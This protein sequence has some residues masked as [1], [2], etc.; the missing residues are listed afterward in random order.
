MPWVA[1]MMPDLGEADIC[2]IKA[3]GEDMGVMRILGCRY[4]FERPEIPEDDVYDAPGCR[5]WLLD[6]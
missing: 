5:R 1:H 2:E 3:E 4:L 6:S